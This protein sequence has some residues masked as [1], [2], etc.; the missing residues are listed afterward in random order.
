MRNKPEQRTQ[1]LEMI[2][3]W[4]RSDLSQKA[5]CSLHKLPYHVFHY[6]Y[7]VYR[8]NK[9]DTGSFIPLHITHEHNKDVI[10][11]TGMSGIKIQIPLT[12]NSVVLIK[13]LLIA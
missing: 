9:A 1:M 12:A 2:A 4:Q 7:R 8:K 11:I 5:Y 6:W 3:Q 10:T 13:Q